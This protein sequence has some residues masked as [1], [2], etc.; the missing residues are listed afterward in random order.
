M[1]EPENV[2][3]ARE[4]LETTGRDGYVR[5]VGQ[6]LDAWE[7]FEVESETFE[8]VGERHVLIH[9]TQR[10]V[11]KESGIEVEMRIFYMLE[12]EGGMATRVHLYQDRE[13]ALA[14]AQAG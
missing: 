13:Q 14:A 12:V 3:L 2:V 10:G 7:S 6:W 8:P 5:W 9:V 4:G 1:S 11:G